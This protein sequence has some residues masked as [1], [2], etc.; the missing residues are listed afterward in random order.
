MT[1]RRA[2]SL[3]PSIVARS[4][5]VRTKSEAS[6]RLGTAV[7]ASG[8]SAHEPAVLTS[9]GSRLVT[10]L[11]LGNWIAGSRNQASTF[12]SSRTG[13]GPSFRWS[14]SWPQTSARISSAVHFTAALPV[15]GPG[16]SH[17]EMS[18]ERMPSTRPS[19]YC[20]ASR[21]PAQNC[22][23]ET[24]VSDHAESM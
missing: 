4:V 19:P 21:R 23:C 1:A 24:E 10:S 15:R 22:A 5:C 6:R 20:S 12:A 8:R 17:S 13:A 7:A 16:R 14:A 3:A 11:A 2:A 18:T 9:S